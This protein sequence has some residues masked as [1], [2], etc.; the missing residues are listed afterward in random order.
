MTLWTSSTRRRDTS[1][2]GR[3]AQSFRQ[4]WNLDHPNSTVNIL[5]YEGARV[6]ATVNAAGY[7]VS[8][9]HD[10]LEGDLVRKRL[11][12]CTLISILPEAG[13]DDALT[14]LVECYDHFYSPRSAPTVP[15][16]RTLS[17]TV[18]SVDEAGSLL[19]GE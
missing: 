11:L 14:T 6:E 12:G 8:Y 13:V 17:G 5:T 18:V 3:S 9:Q 2:A 4:L 1:S 19:I 10:S 7:G 16:H 15:E